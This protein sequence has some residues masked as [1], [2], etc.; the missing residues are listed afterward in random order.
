MLLQ[1]RMSPG[2]QDP[3]DSNGAV[4][5]VEGARGKE[6]E[7]GAR[8]GRTSDCGVTLVDL[9]ENICANQQPLCMSTMSS[10]DTQEKLWT[11]K[12]PPAPPPPITLRKH[13]ECAASQLS[14]KC[15]NSS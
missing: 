11:V 7:A 8:R 12:L 13:I 4:R 3:S 15:L 6:V 10:P 5:N 2:F 14:L 1:L 9:K